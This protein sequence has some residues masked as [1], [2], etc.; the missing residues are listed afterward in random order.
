MDLTS[1]GAV[2]ALGFKVETTKQNTYGGTTP[3][4]FCFD[5]LGGSPADCELGAMT[6]LDAQPM[7][8]AIDNTNA[9][10]KA[11]KLIRNGQVLIIREGKTYN[12]IGTE[13]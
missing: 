3:T 1:L 11:T 4:Y 13:L 8:T 9:D 12:V 6:E 5:N 2:D 10:V 7:P